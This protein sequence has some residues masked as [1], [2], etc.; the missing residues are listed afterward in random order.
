MESFL[1][2]SLFRIRHPDCCPYGNLLDNRSAVPFSSQK[3]WFSA[4]VR[5][6]YCLCLCFRKHRIFPVQPLLLYLLKT[7]QSPVSVLHASGHSQPP[8]GSEVPHSYGI[9]SPAFP[10]NPALEIS[11]ASELFRI[12]TVSNVPILE[13]AS[14]LILSSPLPRIRCSMDVYSNA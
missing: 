10:E 8:A 1:P 13:K 3:I 11:T 6:F 2:Q 7:Q 4:P 14:F 5:I 9:Y 12:V